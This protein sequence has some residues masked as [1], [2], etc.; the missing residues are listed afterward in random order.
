MT[1]VSLYL[2]SLLELIRNFYNISVTPKIFKKVIINDD[3][4]KA[5]A[6]DCIA[7]VVLTNCE[8]ELSYILAELLNKCL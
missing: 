2:F 6:P 7:V 3:L 8:P 4:S 1:Q 5:S